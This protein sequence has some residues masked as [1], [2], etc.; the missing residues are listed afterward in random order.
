MPMWM[1][2]KPQETVGN[3][4]C[5]L[6]HWMGPHGSVFSLQAIPGFP[7]LD[8]N[9]LDTA[10]PGC[11]RN[12]SMLIA[13]CEMGKYKGRG[14]IPGKLRL[15]YWDSGPLGIQNRAV[16]DRKMNNVSNGVSRTTTFEPD[17]PEK[18]QRP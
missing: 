14:R 8:L 18:P 6:P 16:N 9:K 10:V 5:A 17:R 2:M 4:P 3:L 7:Q 1:H 15:I 12:H 13:R 11:S